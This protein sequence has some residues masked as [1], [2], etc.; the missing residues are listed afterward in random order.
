MCDHVHEMYAS[1]IHQHKLVR[2]CCIVR[3][4][5]LT[6]SYCKIVQV[7]CNC[8]CLDAVS[9]ISRRAKW[10]ITIGQFITTCVVITYSH[11]SSK[12]VQSI[13]VYSF[14]LKRVVIFNNAAKFKADRK[15]TVRKIL[16]AVV[17]PISLIT[18]VRTWLSGSS[19]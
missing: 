17:Y 11:A 16:S 1:Y 18:D 5:T 13:T 7:D 15:Y 8:C 9:D 12:A 14:G 19:A 2:T 6:P 3:L 4:T 10:L